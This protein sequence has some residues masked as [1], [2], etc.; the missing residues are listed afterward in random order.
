VANQEDNHRGDVFVAAPDGAGNFKVLDSPSE[1]GFAFGLAW[2]PDGAHVAGCFNTL[3]FYADGTTFAA[4]ASGPFVLPSGA[5]GTLPLWSPDSTRVAHV[6]GDGVHVF[7]L[8]LLSTPHLVPAVS[9]L[10]PDETIRFGTLA[11][12]PD[13]SRVAFLTED[14]HVSFATT[15]Y[16]AE[17]VTPTLHGTD[18]RVEKFQWTPDPWGIV[19]TAD[20]AAAKQIELF[21]SPRDAASLVTV[22]PPLVFGGQVLDFEVR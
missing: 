18:R 22:S 6:G 9:S 4:P 13:G 16:G 12:A 14:L 10:A 3:G 2:A 1:G 17:R 21:F 11:W 15:N 7:P 8:A 20:I 5:A 19:F